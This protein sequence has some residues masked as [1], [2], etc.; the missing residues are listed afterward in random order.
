MN[1]KPKW[2][3]KLWCD[4]AADNIVA[5]DMDYPASRLRRIFWR[6][7]GFILMSMFGW[8]WQG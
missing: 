8:W 1:A 2:V 4:G 3:F 5:Q 6:V 7:R